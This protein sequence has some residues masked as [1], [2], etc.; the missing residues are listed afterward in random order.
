MAL[1]NRSPLQCLP[2]E[3][4]T[5]QGGR[6]HVA[7][8]KL[9]LDLVPVGPDLRVQGFT[10]F[11]KLAQ[12]QPA[13]L[14]TD[15]PFG[16]PL[17]GSLRWESEL[18]P[19]KPRCDVLLLGAAHAPRAQPRR[20]FQASLRLLIP[21]PEAVSGSRV[22]L[23]KR[24]Q[25]T[26]PR[27]LQRRN[28]LLRTCWWCVKVGTLGLIRRCP[29]KLTRPRPVAEVPLRYE[30]SYG[31]WVQV[32]AGER[33]FRRVPRRHWAAGVDRASLQKAQTGVLAE[34]GWQ[35]NPVGRGYAP[36]WYLRAAKLKR[37]AAPQ[38]EDPDHPFTARAAWRVMAGKRK[39]EAA[40]ALQPQGMAP[41]TRNWAARLQFSGTWD[42]AWVASG[43]PYPA[44]FRPEFW[45]CAH[46]DLQC[47]PLAGD[48][49]LELINLCPPNGPGA[50]LDA[51]GNSL[52]RFQLPNLTVIL[53]AWQDSGRWVQVPARLDTLILEPAESR[54]TLI[55]R[56]IHPVDPPSQLLELH[57]TLPGEPATAPP[58]P[59]APQPDLLE[60]STHGH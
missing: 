57:L 7:V 48:E 30:Y 5:P 1:Q 35:A 10:H 33:A 23:S 24:L 56:A 11:L 59:F 36:C 37:L 34:A 8:V 49:I 14:A 53:W 19:G 28:F 15:A 40:P 44:D 51:Q 21:D 6:T 32:K 52:M 42:A 20:R 4:N 38:I 25:V 22:L 29:W 18:A 16:D 54:V 50:V 17:G 3:A 39:A 12:E 13:I 58:H 55:Q 9:T 45:N 47:P 26:G 2:F 31:G 60:A 41:F 46:P 43:T 27:W